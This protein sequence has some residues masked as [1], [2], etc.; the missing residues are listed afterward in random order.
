MIRPLLTRLF[1][2]L[3]LMMPLFAVQADDVISEHVNIHQF[4]DLIAENSDNPNIEIIDVRTP[5]E[6]HSGHIA[7]AVVIDFYGKG[8][9]NKLEQLD[10]NKTYLLYCRSGNRS[11]KTLKLMR[12]LGFKAA[13]N[14]K[15]GM[16]KW[17]A[18]KQAVVKP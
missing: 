4:A 5:R 1:T 6:F 8:F 2:T 9:V 14:M 10:K 15:G 3:F 7:N 17:T 18:A 12:K 16:N 13:Y 11:G